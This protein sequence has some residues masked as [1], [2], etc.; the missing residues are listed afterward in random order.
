M[1]SLKASTDLQNLIK[2]IVPDTYFP[3]GSIYLSTSKT[4]PGTKFG[5][6]WKNVGGD[7]YLIG[8]STNT[9]FNRPGT[10][11]GSNGKSGSW[12]TD[13]TSISVNQMP[14][15]A[16][17]AGLNNSGEHEHVLWFGGGANSGTGAQ[18][19]VANQRWG[20]DIAGQTKGTHDH[21]GIWMSNTGGGQG[22]NHFHVSPYFI[23][24]I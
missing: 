24:V 7:K 12:N 5:G 18:I 6:T 14:A 2:K 10:S 17:S 20:Q 13:N 4:N 1:A 23:V 3:V 11:T 15:H 16:H 8:Y 22:H 21:G 9:W 19:P